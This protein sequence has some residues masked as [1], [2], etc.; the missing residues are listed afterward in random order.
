[1]ISSLTYVE[2]SSWDIPSTSTLT[3]IIGIISGFN[4]IRV[5]EPTVSS[6]LLLTKSTCPLR[7]II[8]ESI[9][10]SCENSSITILTFSFDIEVTF[11][12]PLTVEK[13]SSKGFVTVFSTFSGL[14]P[15]Y[16]VYAIT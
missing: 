13:T 12:T 16:G 11:S 14:A 10:V 4:F 3:I 6:N 5:V 15:G 2:I 7:S 8:A 1:M 9:F